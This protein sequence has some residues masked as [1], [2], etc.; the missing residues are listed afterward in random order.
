MRIVI[1]TNVIASGIFFGGKPKMLLEMVVTRRLDA[2]VSEEILLEYQETVEEL[3]SRYPS[4]PHQL[5]LAHIMSSMN[6]IDPHTSIQ[7]C[8]DPDDDKFIECA[9]DA[10]CIYIVSGDKDLLAVG[11]YDGVKIVTVAEF[12]DQNDPAVYK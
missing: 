2:F 1:D 9:V 12:F 3:C 4:R 7:V 6:M 10:Q 5:P 11:Q 8:R